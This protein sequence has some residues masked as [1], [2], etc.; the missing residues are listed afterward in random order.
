MTVAPRALFPAM[1]LAAALAAPAEAA[2]PAPLGRLFNTPE[3]RA[4]LDRKRLNPSLP[5]PATSGPTTLNGR[6]LRSSGRNTAW[7]NGAPVAEERAPLTPLPLKPG[8]TLAAPDDR[9]AKDLLDGGTL[10]VRPAPQ[11]P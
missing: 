11:R 3:Q 2:E 7:I 10:T 8:Q 6:V 5:G 1:V 9:S 4:E